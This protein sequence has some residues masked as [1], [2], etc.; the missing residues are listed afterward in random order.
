MPMRRIA[1]AFSKRV[2]SVVASAA[3]VALLFPRAAHAWGPMHSSITE[4]AFD[5]LRRT[6]ESGRLE[7]VSQEFFLIPVRYRDFAD[8]AKRHFEVTHSER[9]VNDAQRATV[10]RLF[11]ALLGPEGVTLKQQSRVDLVRKPG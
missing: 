3:M 6:V 11:N 1:S 4:A 2:A 10:E 5:A 9:R 8:F 7:L